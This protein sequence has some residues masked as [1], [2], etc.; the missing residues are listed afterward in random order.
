MPIPSGHKKFT[1]SRDY[2]VVEFKDQKAYHSADEAQAVLD[3]MIGP[4][5]LISDFEDQVHEEMGDDAVITHYRISNG[6]Y[7]SSPHLIRISISGHRPMSQEEIDKQRARQSSNAKRRAAEKT[8][9]RKELE[10]TVLK[11]IKKDPELA[12]ILKAKLEGN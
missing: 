10:A 3:A 8:A 9:K 7:Y 12:L 1:W 2:V 6:Y 11:E 4:R 5:P